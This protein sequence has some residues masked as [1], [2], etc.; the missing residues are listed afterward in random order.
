[1][2]FNPIALNVLLALVIFFLI[3]TAFWAARLR[4]VVTTNFVD[5]VQ[6]GKK[7]TSYGKDQPAGNVYY[8]WPAWL[9][10]VGVQVS[11]L[12][13]SVFSVQLNGYAAY[14]KGRVP[15]LIDILAFFRITE[16]NV[17]A[18]RVSSVAELNKQLEGIL[19]GVCRTILARSEI[20]S[21]LEGR[22]E[23]GHMFTQE[24][25][26]N[27]A[28]WGIQSVKQIELMDIHDGQGSQVIQNIMAKKKSLIE[29]ESRVEV[30]KNLKTA[31]VAEIEAR[32]AVAVRDQESTQA[33]GVRRA[34]QD[35]EVQLAGQR[36]AQAVAEEQ[37]TTTAKQMEVRQVEQVRAA[38]I[39][40][41]VAV[42]AADQAKKVV[43]VEAEGQKQQRVT[44]AEGVLQ[45]AKLTAEGVRAQGEAKGAAE[46]AVLMAPVTAQISLAEK[47]GSSEGYQRY[48]V[49]VRG[50]EKDQAVG[51][52]TAKA[53]QAAGIKVIVNSGE[54]SSGV[55]NLLELFSPKGGT[56]L[57]AAVEAFTQTPAGAAIA[58]RLGVGGGANGADASARINSR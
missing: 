5:I 55:S 6:T 43:I 15:F 32:Q 28:Q 9:P 20:E 37:R 24:V 33:V 36:A 39:S 42:V 51:I 29:M 22:S 49:E 25:D 46:T 2:M 10:L 45:E 54:V 23:F 21:I 34:E 7:T 41:D 48:L 11:R 53:L 35:R 26:T 3:F 14:D 30:A 56:A 47:I 12:P 1:M 19:Q 16:T 17:A 27:L 31:Q 40:R 13:M 58:K 18:Q 38:E 4:T 44:L 8:R 50:I 52:E 57:S